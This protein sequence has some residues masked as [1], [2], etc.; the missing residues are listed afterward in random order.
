MKESLRH[1]G[2]ALAPALA[3]RLPELLSLL[4]HF[5]PPG[6]LS[7]PGHT[8][9]VQAASPG[10]PSGGP[11]TGPSAALSAAR[12]D[13]DQATPA[14]PPCSDADPRQAPTS[15]LPPQEPEDD[16]SSS[17][18][19]PDVLRPSPSSDFPRGT[20]SEGGVDDVSL[21]VL[22]AAQP[23]A[24]L[25]RGEDPGKMA[26]GGELFGTSATA[27]QSLPAGGSRALGSHWSAEAAFRSVG[28]ADVGMQKGSEV[29]VAKLRGSEGF[30]SKV[31]GSEGEGRARG[32][33]MVDVTRDPIWLTFRN[34]ELEQGFQRSVAAKRVKVGGSLVHAAMEMRIVMC[35]SG[36]GGSGPC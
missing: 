10:G 31:H 36:G 23:G 6:L 1:L 35:K 32:R 7:A 11:D 28:S 24:V 3:P 29:E 30:Q 13:P 34:A 16:G 9:D 21:S 8:G 18:T 25:P 17:E 14:S 22:G 33:L 26:S 27:A 5:L 4:D 19:Q 2:N 12:A 15:H 20:H